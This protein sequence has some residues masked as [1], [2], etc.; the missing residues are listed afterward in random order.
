MKLA[1]KIL[2]FNGNTNILKNTSYFGDIGK[3]HA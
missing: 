1:S 3:K 2:L